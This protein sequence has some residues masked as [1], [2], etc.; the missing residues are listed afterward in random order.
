MTD[1]LS[2]LVSL[3]GKGGMCCVEPPPHAPRGHS[4]AEAPVDCRIRTL[5]EL[6]QL[7]I[8]VQPPK[9]VARLKG[10]SEGEGKENKRYTCA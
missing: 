9:G 10:R 5:A 6:L 8:R 4:L 7:F 3:T 2:K 1:T